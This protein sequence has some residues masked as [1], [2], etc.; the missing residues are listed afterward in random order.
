MLY[1]R[2]ILL[3]TKKIYPPRHFLKFFH[4]FADI[5]DYIK[6]GNE[7]RIVSLF[8]SLLIPFFLSFFLIFPFPF[9]FFFPSPLYSFKILPVFLFVWSPPPPGEGKYISLCSIGF[10]ILS[11]TKGLMDLLQIKKGRIVLFLYKLLLQKKFLESITYVEIA[12]GKNYTF[13]IPYFLIIYSSLG[14]KKLTKKQKMPK[15]LITGKTN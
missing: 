9:L 8:Y 5:R 3:P 4:V 2:Y 13:Y 14:R 10:E 7:I 6:Q 15:Y 11:M 1:Q 12:I